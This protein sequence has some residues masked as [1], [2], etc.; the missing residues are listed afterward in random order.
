MPSDKLLNRNFSLVLLG[1]SISLFANSILRFAIS[2]Y[3]LDQTKSAAIY[4]GILAISMIPMIVLSPIGGILAD[5]INRKYIMVAL[6]LITAVIVTVFGFLLP[7][8][9]AIVLI[10]VVMILLSIL[11]SFETPTVQ[12]SIPTLSSRE[13]LIKANAAV[14]QINS[15]SNILGPILGGVLYGFWGLMPVVIVS[16]ICFCSAAFLECFIQM[17]FQKQARE[18]HFLGTM[19][20]DFKEAIRFMT[21]EKP[22]ILKLMLTVT[23]F[24]MFITS[25]VIIGLP[26]IIKITL[27]LSSQL[28]GIAEGIMFGGAIVGGILAGALSKKIKINKIH[29][30]LL[31][32]ALSLIPVGLA[33]AINVSP[34]ISYV[35]INIS[36]VIFMTLATIFSVLGLSFLQGE[37][38]NHLIGKVSSFIVTLSLCA[39]PVGHALYGFL[40]DAFSKQNYIVIGM[41]VIVGA[42]IVAVS[43]KIYAGVQASN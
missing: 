29:F 10:G 41:A 34:I 26:Y 13:N 31:F 7:E 17:P 6:D 20:S 19:L 23:A 2:L 40:Y 36:V 11:S 9:N 28:Y 33:V 1:Q 35:I 25:M 22:I 43:K 27:G 16:G 39:Q 15:L 30:I 8:S 24:N 4:A 5:R 18:T 3:V 12:S 42:I 14:S 21:K 38:P 32:S 37:T